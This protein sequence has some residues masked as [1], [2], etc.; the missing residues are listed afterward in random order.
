MNEK[1]EW[2]FL[3]DCEPVDTSLRTW[4]RNEPDGTEPTTACGCIKT[5]SADFRMSDCICAGFPFQFICQK[6]PMP[7]GATPTPTPRSRDCDDG[8]TSSLG[9]CYYYSEDKTNWINAK[10][11]C[12]TK[13]ANLVEMKTDEEAL[14]VMENLPSCIGPNDL[15]YTGRKVN[16]VGR[17]V[18]GSSG[19]AIDRA[20]RSWAMF[21][22]NREGVQNCGCTKSNG[23]FRMRDCH[24]IGFSLYYICEIMR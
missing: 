13:G 9:K 3:T 14:Y 6:E 23:F 22:P 8:W 4:A 5:L 11:S 20:K 2:V 15:V 10:D 1:D 24:C 19:D 12:E 21:E 18:F 16:D 17:W 7:V